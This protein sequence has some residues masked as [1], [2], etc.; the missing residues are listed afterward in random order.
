MKKHQKFDKKP[1]F[2]Y[3]NRDENDGFPRKKKAYGQHFLRKQSVV[4][5]MIAE[6]KIDEN[7]TIMEIGC[8]DGFLTESILSQTNCKNLI[9]YEID[10]EWAEVVR[11]KISD[12]RLEIIEKNILEVEFESLK[13]K[14]PLVILANLPYQITFPIF[15]LF[16]KHKHLFNEGVVMIQEEV[17]QKIVS[18]TGKSYSA[19]SLF[20]QNH[21]EFKLLEKVEPGA[22]SPPPKVFSRLIYFKPKS[23][24]LQIPQEENFWKFLKLCFHQPRRTLRNN[25]VSNHYSL[26]TFSEK[27]LN[28]RAQQLSIH[29][30]LEAWS[31]LI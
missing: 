19:T 7:T 12:P 26:E 11:N 3:H 14:Q 15:F 4:D 23:E 27:F 22:F 24:T 29:D 21:F 30:F 18:K 1:Y 10:P 9:C 31:K 6:V 28:S 17:A 13:E 5:H 2:S 20:L 16:L 8:G 25:L